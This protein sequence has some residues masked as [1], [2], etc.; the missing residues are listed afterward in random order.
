MSLEAKDNKPNYGL[1]F[2]FI[3]MI[4][5]LFVV[6]GLVLSWFF[7]ARI[8]TALEDEL[9][10]RGTAVAKDLAFKSTFG[11]T[12]G[13]SESLMTL[14]KA[15]TEKLDV[16]YVIIL[17]AQGKVLAHSDASEFGKSYR[18]A[19]TRNS[20]EYKDTTILLTHDAKGAE[21]YEVANPV[22][23][24]TESG[25]ISGSRSVS[26]KIGLV[27][28]GL[29][30]GSLKARLEQ[31]LFWSLLLTTMI[32]GTGI[33]V[34]SFFVRYK[35]SPLERMA[36]IATRI[37]D[38]DF[39]QTVQVL[40]RDEIGVLGAAFSKMSYK[41]NEMI[42]KIQS[43]ANNVT[44]AADQISRTSLRAE[45]GTQVQANAT[46][47]TSSSIEE[48]NSSI[49]EIAENVDV[50]SSA[51]DATSSSILEMTASINEV[52]NSTVNLSGSVEDT[53]ASIVEM[54]AS[55]KQVAQNSE[56]LSSAAEQTSSA[57]TELNASVKEIETN[58]KE[59]ATVSEKVTSDAQLL[60]VVAVEKLI[61]GMNKIRGTVEVSANVINK[62]GERSDQI[63]KILTVIDEVTRQTNLL[64]LNAAILAAQAGE[65]GKGF[66]VVADEI[67]KLADRTASSTKE[68]SQ[69]IVGVQTEAKDAVEA[70]QTGSQS[71]EEG[72][73]L[74]NNVGEAL[75]N[76]LDS[77]K[78]STAMAQ[79]IERATKEQANGIRQITGA[80][81]Q[82]NGMVRQIAK[83]TQEQSRGTEQIMQAA[84]RMRDVTRQVRLSTEEQAKGSKQIT[85]AVE[86]VTER[87][88]QIVKAVNEQ[89]L[90]SQV[91]MK[92]VGEIRGIS[93]QSVQ[94]V[95]QT[96]QA[97]DTLTK[98]SLLLQEVVSRFKVQG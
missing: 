27:R 40:S 1:R 32:I 80:M 5:V 82:I 93:Q 58:S 70:I 89:K 2:K 65:Q 6:L 30:L 53:A 84:E 48:M 97:V 44:S 78:R 86:N 28:V 68:I 42:K 72:M 10:S 51:A 76:I 35:I 7:L 96:N 95:S 74:T 47:K 46:E 62:L 61:Q 52:A 98:Q 4:S 37:A 79:G 75:T 23:T 55:I 67:K 94:L 34:L 3:V 56:V 50:L 12:I 54:S 63:G 17:D 45:E 31:N 91:I 66:A 87:V 59:S 43:V 69:L 81:Q 14:V 92:S 25:S 88:Q 11:V 29:T 33:V 90:G 64:A 41:L 20:L 9:K 73:H 13:D 83:A 16:A 19:V 18:D 24:K 85:Q 39:S 38:G 36:D 8:R 77:S 49:K 71:V 22:V 15:V 21:V 57:V 26:N 60:G